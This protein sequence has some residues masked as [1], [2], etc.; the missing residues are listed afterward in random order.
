MDDAWNRLR[1]WFQPATLEWLFVALGII[2]RLRFFLDDRSLWRDEADLANNLVNRTFSGLT[3]P[4]DY[5]Q[6]APLLFLFLEKGLINLLGN[7]D[8]LLRLFPLFAGC[9][10]LI[11]MGQIAGKYWGTTGLFAVLG[12]AI[13]WPLTYYSAMV[14]QYSGDVMITLL[15]LFL[16]M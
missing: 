15:L 8:Y 2:L 16:A 1:G 9:I 11:L 13:S 7:R 3:Q 12:L 6:G 14:K 4:L 5:N 10:A